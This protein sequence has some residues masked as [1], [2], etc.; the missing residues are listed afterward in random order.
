MTEQFVCAADEV[1]R[2]QRDPE[3]ECRFFRRAV[4]G[5]EDASRGSMQGTYIFAPSGK[6]LARKNTN[7]PDS[8]LEMLRASLKEWKALPADEL[9]TVDAAAVKTGF[10]WEDSYPASG[11]VL[12]RTGRDLPMPGPLSGVFDS[13]PGVRFNRDAVW[14]SAE[15]A[16]SMLPVRHEVGERAL[17]PP[18]LTARLACLVF[19]D[20]VGGQ[21]VPFHPSETAGSELEVVLTAVDAERVTIRIEGVTAASGEGAWFYE[22]DNYW[23]PKPKQE[24]ARS[25]RTRVLGSAVF[26]LQAGRFEHF[27][28][29]AVGARSGRTVFAGRRK[30]DPGWIG[31]VCELAPP[32]WRVAPTFVNVYRVKWIATPD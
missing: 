21:T 16:R 13:K 20:N 28:L 26:D 19:V 23:K 25:I 6:L 14:F 24:R 22:D 27:E 3:P 15:E 8:I 10:R 30:G 7:S 2:L 31:F 11:L 9:K 17:L 4:T 12:R 32:A 5:T 18:A 1:W 29:V